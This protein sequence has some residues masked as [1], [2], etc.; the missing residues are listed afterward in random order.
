MRRVQFEGGGKKRRDRDPNL[1]QKEQDELDFEEKALE[2]VAAGGATSFEVW[3]A[4]ENEANERLNA[5][6]SSSPKGYLYLG[7]A[8]YK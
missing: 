4:L 8:F 5:T 3:E 7:V 6:G 1:S 2:V